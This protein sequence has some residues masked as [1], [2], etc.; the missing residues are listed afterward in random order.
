MQK[1]KGDSS[2]GGGMAG[3][4]KEGRGG[5]GRSPVNN[6]IMFSSPHGTVLP[7]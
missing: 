7:P 5:K 3:R 4:Q 6:S 2:E 1:S